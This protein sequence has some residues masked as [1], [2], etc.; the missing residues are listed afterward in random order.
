MIKKTVEY[1]R[2]PKKLFYTILI[3]L[4]LFSVFKVL[5]PKAIPVD[6]TTVQKGLFQKSVIDE[7]QTEFKQKHVITAPGDGI[8][9][10]LKLR[11]GD[12]VKKDELLFNFILDFDFKV[13]SPVDGY[14]LRVFEK[15]KRHVVRGTK[16]LE[17]GNPS[18]IEIIAKLLSEEVVDVKIGQ[19]ALIT[20]W[21]KEEKLEAVITK[22][23][24]SAKEEVSA[25]GVKEQRVKVHMEFTTEKSVWENLGDGYRVEVRVITKEIPDSKLIPIS[26]LFTFEEKPSIFTIQNG[27]AVLQNLDIIDRNENFA[28]VKNGP[29]IGASLV[30]YPGSELESGDKIKPR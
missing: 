3:I 6:V 8:V 19:K 30:M 13:K 17:I 29:E 5:K 23:E 21:G 10:T 18:K 28:L 26:S 12:P 20:K 7:G 1:I 14:V 25:L 16:I 2:V 15:D 27:K 24:P 4:V 11:A 22:I 9:P